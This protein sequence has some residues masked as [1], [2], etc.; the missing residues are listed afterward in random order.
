MKQ[1]KVGKFL[2][3]LRHEK[4]LTQEAFGKQIGVTNKTI[5]RWETG[6][7]MP[8][9]EMLLIL[10][11]FYGVSITEILSGERLEIIELKSE[12]DRNFVKLTKKANRLVVI[13]IVGIILLAVAIFVSAK[14]KEK[15]YELSILNV[16][17]PSTFTELPINTGKFYLNGDVSRSYFEIKSL[18]SEVLTLEA[19]FNEEDLKIIFENKKKFPNETY[20]QFLD[21]HKTTWEF[22]LVCK[23]VENHALREKQLRFDI[24]VDVG[25]KFFSSFLYFYI[26]ENAFHNG[27]EIYI[28]VEE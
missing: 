1:E 22:P 11:E 27:N 13:I 7:Y 24:K 28:R 18:N 14:L 23:A 6:K 16:N 5:S 21:T 3:E 12:S 19:F 2:S 17:L 10:S 9:I 20:E 25:Q 8:D 26:N 15:S 4:G